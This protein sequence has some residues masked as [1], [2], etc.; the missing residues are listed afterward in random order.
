MNSGLLLIREDTITASARIKRNFRL[1]P[2]A[3]P[4]QTI[5]TT[6]A[7]FIARTSLAPGYAHLRASCYLG[8]CE[9]SQCGL[10][11]RRIALLRTFKRP[12]GLAPRDY[13][14][15]RYEGTLASASSRP[16]FGCRSRT[17]LLVPYYLN[18][19][20]MKGVP[21]PLGRWDYRDI[22]LRKTSRK[23]RECPERRE[24]RKEASAQEAL[25]HR[26]GGHRL[27]NRKDVGLRRVHDHPMLP[28]GRQ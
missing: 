10:A 16:T 5:T 15:Q 20:V 18:L 9:S 6:V 22:P 21:L 2:S 12:F 17:V 19:P 13:S 26:P 14:P 3:S 1:S 25:A 11:A 8:C 28:G 27:S 4:D 7:Y 24:Q 23:L